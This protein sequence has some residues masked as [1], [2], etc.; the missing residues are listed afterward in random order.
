MSGLGELRRGGVIGIL[1]GGQLGRMLAVE[2]ASL[3]YHCHIYD[4]D[5]LAPAKQ[6]TPAFTT[7]AYDDAGAL[8]AFA[9]A[10][11]V[12]TYE[13]ENIPLATVR[14]LAAR[15]PVH[16]GE[17]AL[18]VAQDRLTEKDFVNRVGG[19]TT[20]YHTVDSVEDG[21]VAGAKLGFPF[22]LKTRRM[23]YDGKG[24]A[25][26]QSA[27]AVADAVAQLG[28]TDLIA[29]GFVNFA[30]EL[31]IIL[32]RGADGAVTAYP[33]VENRHTNHI[34]DVTIAP[35]DVSDAMAEAARDVATA[36]VT[37]LD[38]VGVLAVELFEVD[39]SLL[40]NEIAPRVH[41]SGHWT[42]DACALGQ[43]A[44]HIRA[45]AG[46]PLPAVG[47]HS[48]AVMK[49]LLGDEIT[50]C[51]DLMAEPGLC[52]H[53]YGKAEARPGRKMG[54]VTRLYPL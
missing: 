25:M 17:T 5:P 20:P 29:E 45:V 35:A 47:V 7:A 15:V 18:A 33:L 44:A 34:L 48:R 31:S 49:N 52:F 42:M 37:T 12:V 28:G 3:G 6:V 16:P 46:L 14:H 2:A 43:F 39:G 27:D 32:A 21:Q 40:V 36:L 10:V 24:Q 54:H 30:R 19:E 26:I 51:A 11:D 1:G 41:N 50:N 8:D 38:Y 22:V 4:P 53:D 9:A 13:F 23:G